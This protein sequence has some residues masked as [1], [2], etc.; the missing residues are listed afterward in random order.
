MT[1]IRVAEPI[2]TTEEFESLQE[3]LN[4]RG[5]DQPARQLGGATQFLGD[6]IC[7]DYD[8]NMTVEKTTTKGRP[9]AYLRCSK[10]KA[11]G[12]GAPNPDEIYSKLVDDVLKVLGDE[13]VM[14]REYRQGAEA[15]KEQ[16]RLEQSVRYYMSGLEPEGRF[17]KTRFTKEQAEK[18]LDGLIRQLN[19]LDP[20]S[21]QDRWVA[22]H[23]GKSFRTRWQ[24]GGMEAMSA[25]LFRVGV[26]CKIK[27]ARVQGVP[28]PHIHMKLM[29]PKDVRDRLILKEDDFTEEF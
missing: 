22:V 23:N 5:Q 4:R 3:V 2:F 6:L 12:R 26:K 18:T 21:T 29:I 28:A 17:T 27:R 9:Y 24:E 13:P 8:T 7:D 1:P 16:E 20:D 10:C 25:D 14:T 11:S 19:E 15:R